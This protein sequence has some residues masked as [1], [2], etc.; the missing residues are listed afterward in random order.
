M[1]ELVT[2]E[3]TEI[4]AWG[5]PILRGINWSIK[6]NQHYAV[7]G[8]IGAGKT[9]L[10]K[11]L[12]GKMHISQG[13]INYPFLGDASN[14]QNRNREIKMVSFTDSTKLFSGVNSNHYYQQRYNAFDADG[15]LTA[16]DYLNSYNFDPH[17]TKH[18]SIVE[19]LGITELL[20]LERIK[21][22]SGQTR[23]LILAGALIEQPTILWLD[24]PHVGLD[25]KG[26]EEFN[27]LIDQLTQM[28]KATFILSG[29]FHSLPQS[30]TS[31]IWLENGSIQDVSNQKL[32]AKQKPVSCQLVDSFSSLN[33]N[34][35]TTIIE[36]Q[37]VEVVYSG[38]SIFNHFN[39]KV[40]PGEKW[41][42]LGPNGSGKSTLLSFIYADHPQVYANQISLFGRP[43]GQGESIW[44]V[45]SKIGFTSPELHAYFRHNFTV[46]Q[47]IGTG[48]WDRFVLK[49]I[50][51]KK[52]NLIRLLLDHFDLLSIQH[53]PYH[54]LST[55]T[56]RLC[57]FLRALIK[58]PLLLLLDEP[59]QALDEHT[60]Y[61]CNDLLSQILTPEHTLIFISHF[62][63]HTPGLATQ[64]LKLFRSA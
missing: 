3:D 47:L 34:S 62:Q 26:R 12:C 22:S 40:N 63:S 61:Q 10:G 39:W 31:S 21:L 38:V 46:T 43:R 57:F 17:N 25:S 44:D 28:E 14:Y 11:A 13:K 23:K 20:G 30:I 33:L 8:N 36:M 24:N 19:R 37:D 35:A 42:V 45:K 15:H 29:H 4:S 27:Q 48:L 55:G 16:M 64:Y 41:V 7:L 50:P 9:I 52:L 54:H 59:Y 51:E 6:K 18:K 58:N 32:H 60:I 53:T 56:Q 49:K 2:F 1:T 5:G